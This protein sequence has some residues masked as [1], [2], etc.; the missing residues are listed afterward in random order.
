MFGSG[1]LRYGK[2]L[3]ARPT[4]ISAIPLLRQVASE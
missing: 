4:G 3:F 2:Y 1:E